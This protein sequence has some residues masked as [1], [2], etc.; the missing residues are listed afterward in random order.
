M[1]DP[2]DCELFNNKAEFNRVFTKY[3]GRDWFD[4]Q[5]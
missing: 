2:K 4:T 1:N 3:L 5:K